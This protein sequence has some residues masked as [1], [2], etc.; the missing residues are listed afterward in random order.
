MVSLPPVQSWLVEVA[1]AWLQGQLQ[2][3]VYIHEVRVGLPAEAV[4]SKVYV[5]DDEG[6]PFV[7]LRELRI[8]M[9]TFSLW[10]FLFQ[11]EQNQTLQV[12]RITLVEPHFRLYRRARDSLL[13][14]A[15]VQE[16]F[17]RE[18]AQPRETGGKLDV[19]L[20]EIELRGGRFTYYDPIRP[21]ADSLARGRLNFSNLSF[22]DI[23]GMLGLSILPSGR[24]A[25]RVDDLN[26]QEEHSGLELKQFRLDLVRDTLHRP[27][28]DASRA[29]VPFVRIKNLFAYTDQTLLR[30]NLFFPDETLNELVD[31][32]LRETLD[33][34]L[35][36]SSIDV[37]TINYFLGQPLPLQGVLQA[38]G[39]VNGTMERLFSPNFK[40]K[41]LDKTSLNSSW[42][43]RNLLDADQLFMDVRFQDSRFNGGELQ[44]LLPEVGLPAALQRIDSLQADG[45][46]LG[47]YYDFDLQVQAGTE[48]GGLQADVHIDLPPKTR[49]P[50]YEGKLTTRQFDLNTLVAQAS[51]LSPN[52]SLQA[53]VKGQGNALRNLQLTANAQVAPSEIV[54][55]RFDTAQVALSIENEH[56]YADVF[57]NDGEGTAS[58]NVDFH[59]G[60][61]EVA[62][63]VDGQ[64]N[65]LNLQKY[66]I[67]RQPIWLSTNLHMD[68]LGD[69][70]DNAQGELRL[71]GAELQRVGDT[72]RFAIPDFYLRSDSNSSSYTSM[73]LE[74]SLF[75]GS[76]SGNFAIEKGVEL[77]QRLIRE[78]SLYLA[79]DDSLIQAYYAQKEIDSV[80]VEVD[81]RGVT[82]T[83]INEVFRFLGEPIYLSPYDTLE[84]RLQFSN[85]EQAEI[86]L[87]LDS[88]SYRNLVL[89]DARLNLNL[90]KYSLQNSLL[91]A[92]DLVMDSLKVAQSFSLEHLTLSLN[93]EGREL[94]STFQAEQM[95]GQNYAQ[96]VINS[97]FFP[98]GRILTA[99]N[100]LSQLKI[101]DERWRFGEGNA[102]NLEA[103]GLYIDQLRLARKDKFI[104]VSGE[105]TKSD[106][107]RLD[108]ML[109]EL[110]LTNVPDI[111]SLP[112]QL[113]GVLT[114]GV[115]LQN[116]LNAPQVEGVGTVQ[117]FGLDDFIYGDLWIA[118]NWR[119]E[120]EQLE[121]DLRLLDGNLQDTTLALKGSYTPS[122]EEESLNFQV[123]TKAPFPL[124]YIYPFVKSQLSAIKG[125]VE[126]ESFKIGGTPQEPDVRGRGYF[127]EAGFNVEYFKTAYTFD[128]LIEFDKNLISFPRRSGK[129]AIILQD[130]NQHQAE[131]YGA[132]RHNGLKEFEFDLQLDKMNNFLVMDTR[133][134]DNEL[135]YGTV[136][137]KN[138]VASIAG[139]L[140]KLDVQGFAIT[141]RG[142]QLKIPVS[143]YSELQKPDFIRFVGASDTREDV[144]NTGLQGFDLNLSIQA[145]PDAQVELIFDEKVGDI[146]KGRGAGNLN[147]RINEDGEFNMYGEY[148]IDQGDYLFTARNLINKKFEVKSGGRIVWNGDP[149][150]AQIELDA[151]YSLYA[152]IRELVQEERSIRVP[153]NVLMHLQGSLMRPQIDL[154]I[155]LPNLTEQ[156]A[157]M[158]VSYLKTIQYDEQE[159][160]KQVFS[161]MVF[162]RFAPAGGFL[163]DQLA[164]TGVTTSVSEMLSNQLNYW[165]SKAMDDNLSVSV[166]TS[167]FQDVDLLVSAKLFNDRVTIERD[168]TLVNG[169]TGGGPTVGNISLIIKLLP[170]ADN[171]PT[172]NNRQPSQLVLEV[173]NRESL[174]LGSQNLNQNQTGIGLF[175]QKDF[176]DLQD[177]LTKVRKQ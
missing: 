6:V 67:Y 166:G 79:N 70:L 56:L 75:N 99:I 71:A 55:Y 4:L 116:L 15:F 175:F 172:L 85:I 89:K 163:G 153:V 104:D 14:L 113:N 119:D 134:E 80:D 61:G 96:L 118:S 34:D 127:T 157:L 72:A 173:F 20:S 174:R 171:Q 7:Q 38:E 17:R 50:A 148:E 129:A 126:L 22:I 152:D 43:L 59:L 62:Y 12:N 133:K 109:N 2:T 103:G 139:D 90:I 160:N 149:Y 95:D 141:G 128:G 21:G 9:L 40:V 83:G 143:F 107:S 131:F 1:R 58:V 112:Y 74:S 60:Q 94:E 81:V 132:I 108:L 13:N 82:Q 44:A 78:S 110:E 165:L 98:D 161:L 5:M 170:T 18:D 35:Q 66:R 86:S 158:V 92:G 19:V 64:L 115:S 52:L 144:R 177:L 164:S 88:A 65:R 32:E 24:L 42:T 121:V 46:L 27:Q 145:T 125:K 93:G 122:L 57:A 48:L 30:A 120:A 102:F 33:L 176:D 68:V 169:Q 146:I 73:M 16:A 36:P 23:D 135:F 140:E 97:T 28:P 63:R 76:L 31:N 138:G 162:N 47:N 41:Y 45:R 29:I 10:R 101:G 151:V 123:E 111:V 124:N 130:R 3:E 117:G 11:Q 51:N 155:E 53:Q 105:V 150:E 167:N 69:S 37:T 87:S 54:G 142:S 100:P 39:T 26:F 91:L 168:G 114:M 8:D 77:T 156:N 25:L 49:L 159:L 154:S 137:I 147:V 84:A 106:T 136:I